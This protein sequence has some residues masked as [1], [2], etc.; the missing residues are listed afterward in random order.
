MY[1]YVLY[2]EKKE[3]VQVIFSLNIPVIGSR[4]GHSV[5]FIVSFKNILDGSIFKTNNLYIFFRNHI[6]N[7]RDF[8][9]PDRNFDEQDRK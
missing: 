6:R 7:T 9:E 5:K 3:L 8:Y 4:L 2:P 1:V